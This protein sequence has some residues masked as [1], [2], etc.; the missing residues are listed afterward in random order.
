MLNMFSAVCFLYGR[1]LYDHLKVYSMCCIFNGNVIDHRCLLASLKAHGEGLQW[2]L[3]CLTKPLRSAGSTSFLTMLVFCIV[4]VAIFSGSRHTKWG[5]SVL[6][7]NDGTTNQTY[8]KVPVI[9]C[10]CILPLKGSHMVSRRNQCV[11]WEPR[12]LR[13]CLSYYDWH[14]A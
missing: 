7:C 13:M 14:M 5:E 10:R 11:E 12:S 1:I 2:R 8:D 4:S 3:G 9:H 6:A